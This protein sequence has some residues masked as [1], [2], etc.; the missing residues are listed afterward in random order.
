MLIL[1]IRSW[2][3][4]HLSEVGN[5]SL[6][7]EP[8][9]NFFWLILLS[10]LTPSVHFLLITDARPMYIGAVLEQDG[11]STIC[12]SRERTEPSYSQTQWVALDVFWATKRL[13]E[14]LFGKKSTIVTDHEALKFIYHPGKSLVHFTVSMVQRWI[15]AFSAYDYTV[16][17][18]RLKK[19]N[20]LITYICNHYKISLLILHTVF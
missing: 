4:I 12:V 6:A 3:R 13:H 19:L 11:S 14:Y 15:I 5:K 16:R 20:M 7:C 9:Q 1:Y 18:K 10:G 17:Q 8:Y 2:H